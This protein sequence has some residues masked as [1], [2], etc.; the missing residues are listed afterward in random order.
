M[1]FICHILLLVVCVGTFIDCKGGRGGGGGRGS[2]G[3][4]WS[5]QYFQYETWHGPHQFSLL[6]NSQAMK[7]KG[8][9]SD[10]NGVFSINGFY[11]TKTNRIVLKKEYESNTSNT[12]ENSGHPVKIELMWNEENNQF[13]GNWYINTIVYKDSG[14]FNLQFH[15]KSLAI[16][17]DSNGTF[18][19][20]TFYTNSLNNYVTHEDYLYLLSIIN[21]QLK[22]LMTNKYLYMISI[23]LFG[24]V[25]LVL[26]ALSVFFLTD[27]GDFGYVLISIFILVNL[28]FLPMLKYSIYPYYNYKVENIHG[29]I[30]SLVKEFSSQT[31]TSQTTNDLIW[32][33][34]FNDDSKPILHIE[35]PPLCPKNPMNP[36]ATTSSIPQLSTDKFQSEI[37]NQIH[38]SSEPVQYNS[39][40]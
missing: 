14:K 39:I 5:S 4:V 11:S 6:F 20:N 12:K 38:S 17:S 31:N 27:I 34:E 32:N 8:T 13:E 30:K 10:D 26:L 22:Q 35:C 19:V 36:I 1:R 33:I 15:E 28:I 24:A 7:I 18:N 2:I 21:P 40:Q 3:G 23:I 16:K 29:S 37:A 9:G 25:Y